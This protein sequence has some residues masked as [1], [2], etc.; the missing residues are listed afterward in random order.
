MSGVTCQV[1]FVMCHVSPVTCHL[2][3]VT[4][5]NSHSHRP[6]ALPHFS[7]QD[8]QIRLGADSVKIY[9][10]QTRCSLSCS[11]NTFVIN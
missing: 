1:S 8:D 3:H 11:T 10:E 9:F 6:S 5:T 7:Q 2:S 4:N